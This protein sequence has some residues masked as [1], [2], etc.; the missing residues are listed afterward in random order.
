MPIA[1]G[2]GGTPMFGIDGFNPWTG[3][4][5]RYEAS[6]P[7]L[8][9]VGD[10]RLDMP[11]TDRESVLRKINGAPDLIFTNF[12]Q[13][14]LGQRHWEEGFRAAVRAFWERTLFYNY[15]ATHLGGRAATLT[16][17]IRSDPLHARLLRDMLL[18]YKPSHAIVWGETNWDAIAVADAPWEADPPIRFSEIDEPC[19]SVILE[20]QRTR[21]TRIRHPSAGFAYDRWSGLLSRFLQPAA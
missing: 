3:L 8:M 2:G 9:V 5:G 11:L 7:R 16:A 15:N 19:R 12:E 10:V 18:R 4:D 17:R 13:A 14:V 6:N 1:Q 21:F 20:G